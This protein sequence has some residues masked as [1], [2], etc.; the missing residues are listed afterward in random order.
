MNKNRHTD[1]LF[2]REFRPILTRRQ[3]D[4]ALEHPHK[5]LNGVESV[6]GGDL[7]DGHLHLRQMGFGLLHPADVQIFIEPRLQYGVEQRAQIRS[8]YTQMVRHFVLGKQ[9]VRAVFIDVFLRLIDEFV[10]PLAEIRA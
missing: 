3:A 6:P 10:L 8:V 9:A 5:V 7:R 1:R 4:E 2:L